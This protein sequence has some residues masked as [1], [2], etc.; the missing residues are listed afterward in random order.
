MK[1]K[2]LSDVPDE[3]IL[4][5]IDFCKPFELSSRM[6][7]VIHNARSATSYGHSLNGRNEISV[8]IV[9]ANNK[10]Y[11]YPEL[12]DYGVIRRRIELC[13]DVYVANKR[14]WVALKQS[15]VVA[16]DKRNGYLPILLLSR[17]EDFI[18]VIA[19]E[20]RHQ[21]Q[22]GRPLKSLYVWGAKTKS[23]NRSKETDA[24][25]Y[26]IKKVREWRRTHRT[27]ALRISALFWN[28]MKF[29]YGYS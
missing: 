4:E 7:V 10:N 29:V 12:R 2:N 3:K 13:F 9:S 14:K 25:A 21:W 5:Y 16:T 15:T 17:E 20:L 6:K 26:A 8:S 11:S 19:H 28:R 23:T 24:D 27:D 1:L 18:H 22:H